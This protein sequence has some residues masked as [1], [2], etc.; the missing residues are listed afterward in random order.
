MDNKKLSEALAAL[1]AESGGG[2]DGGPMMVLMHCTIIRATVGVTPGSHPIEQICCV[3][4]RVHAV[5]P[6]DCTCVN[7]GSVSCHLQFVSA[8]E[9]KTVAKELS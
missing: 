1:A 9:G 4:D 3:R 7:W 5:V 6:M 2:R 8:G